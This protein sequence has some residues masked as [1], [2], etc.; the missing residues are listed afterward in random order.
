MTHGIA[1]AERTGRPAS[2]ARDV[3]EAA[4]D[5]EGL[6]L[7][8]CERRLASSWVAHAARDERERASAGSGTSP[9]R[10]R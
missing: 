1:G 10:S 5:D 6:A 3:F 8:W 7:Y 2:G 9:R 4:G